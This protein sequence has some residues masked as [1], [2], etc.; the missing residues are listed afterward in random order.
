[1][2][3]EH[4]EKELLLCFTYD[5]STGTLVRKSKI[6]QDLP[7]R[8]PS[9]TRSGKEYIT[10]TFSDG[11]KTKRTMY[12]HVLV[13]RIV[14]GVWPDN[15]IDHL[16]GDGTN[17]K[18]SNL[19]CV[20]KCI[21]QRNRKLASNNTSGHAGVYWETRCSKWYAKLSINGEQKY[22]GYY[23]VLADAVAARQKAEA[24]NGFTQR[25]AS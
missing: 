25:A 2:S 6:N 1:M 15:D 9:K 8:K 19:R 21:N 18:L 14:Y 13:W 5:K 3:P 10:F 17:N 11:R 4:I 20:P 24:E 16:D 23:S 12:A 7:L 22:L